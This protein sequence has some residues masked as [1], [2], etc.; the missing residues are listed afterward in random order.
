MITLILLLAILVMLVLGGIALVVAFGLGGW[1]IAL[2][3]I[4]IACAVGVIKLIGRI[5]RKKA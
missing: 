1:I 3:A 2:V 5:F 4:D